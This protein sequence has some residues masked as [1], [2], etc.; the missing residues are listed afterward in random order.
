M[1][2]S[3]ELFSVSHLDTSGYIY[4]HDFDPYETST[5]L[6]TE[7]SDRCTNNQLHTIITLQSNMTYVVIITTRDSKPDGR[8]S[9][10]AIGPSDITFEHHSKY[11]KYIQ[12]FSPQFGSFFISYSILLRIDA[13]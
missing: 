12:S 1:T 5:N 2:G 13:G 7:D 10:V 4:E 3:Y 9:I 6:L 8:F 11:T